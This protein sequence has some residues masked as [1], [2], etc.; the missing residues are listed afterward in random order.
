MKVWRTE[1]PVVV[2][3]PNERNSDGEVE[4]EQNGEEGEHPPFNVPGE[5]WDSQTNGGLRGGGGY[6]P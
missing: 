6:G 3:R 2:N 4:D 1:P 5:E